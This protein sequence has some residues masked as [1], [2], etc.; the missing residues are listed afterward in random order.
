MRAA[1]QNDRISRIS[2]DRLKSF[3]EIAHARLGHSLLSKKKKKIKI[4]P[5][6]VYTSPNNLWFSN[7][8]TIVEISPIPRSVTCRTATSRR[9]VV[10]ARSHPECI[11]E[12]SDFIDWP[13][14]DI[15][16]VPDRDRG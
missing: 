10:C 11:L 13:S 16:F 8:S 5:P 15:G 2:F 4:K 7:R 1:N 12:L 3:R 14:S 6:D 9:F